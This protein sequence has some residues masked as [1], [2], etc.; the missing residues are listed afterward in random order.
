MPETLPE[1]GGKGIKEKPGKVRK[2]SMQGEADEEEGAEET[3]YD[4]MKKDMTDRAA[5]TKVS[6]NSIRIP[7]FCCC[8]SL[9]SV[10]V[11]AVHYVFKRSPHCEVGCDGNGKHASALLAYTTQA[12]SRSANL[13][14]IMN[15]LM[16]SLVKRYVEACTD[17]LP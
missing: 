13:L 5:R 8:C 7:G 9:Y 1:G 14:N 6:Q 3:Y 17:R 2:K 11:A 12:E 16:V 4:A 15:S 10:S